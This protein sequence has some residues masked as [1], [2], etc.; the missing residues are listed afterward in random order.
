MGAFLRADSVDRSDI[1]TTSKCAKIR[2]LQRSER[3][4]RRIHEPSKHAME[5]LVGKLANRSQWNLKTCLQNA[6]EGDIFEIC[7]TVSVLSLE[8][9]RRENIEST[10]SKCFCFQKSKDKTDPFHSGWNKCGSDCRQLTSFYEDS[11][12]KFWIDWK[13]Q[14]CQCVHEYFFNAF[15]WSDHKDMDGYFKFQLLVQVWLY[16]E[17]W[18]GQNFEPF[19]PTFAVCRKHK[20]TAL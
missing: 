11:G 8:M 14:Q 17:G 12:L 19:F 16:R 9:A 3:Q 18:S 15:D 4:Y 6:E 20:L 7:N 10:N 2:R 5:R 13:S 1:F